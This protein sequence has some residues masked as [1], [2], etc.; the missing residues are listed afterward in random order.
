MCSA[1]RVVTGE[2]A[3]PSEVCPYKMLLLLLLLA[4]VTLLLHRTAPDIIHTRPI[5]FRCDDCGPLWFLCFFG[6]W[7]ARPPAGPPPSSDSLWQHLKG[8]ISNAP[9][10]SNLSDKAA[11]DF[12]LGSSLALT[13]FPGENSRLHES[14]QWWE[15]TQTRIAAHGL[16]TTTQ[17]GAPMA[18]ERIIDLP[19]DSLPDLPA[20]HPHY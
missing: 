6:E 13:S 14:V 4:S 10:M 2:R 20:D 7:R 3:G 17:G 11:R 15:S 8:S 18:T 12:S 16:L 1:W 5:P 9:A 19:L